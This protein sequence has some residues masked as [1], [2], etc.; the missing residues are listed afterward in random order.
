MADSASEDAFRQW[1]RA[2][3]LYIVS[4]ATCT[5]ALAWLVLIEFGIILASLSSRYADTEKG[6]EQLGYMA[7]VSALLALPLPIFFWVYNKS[8]FL[9]EQ[10]RLGD[11]AVLLIVV[12][13]P[14][15][16]LRTLLAALRWGLVAAALYVAWWAAKKGLDYYNG[17]DNE[18]TNGSK[19]YRYDPE[20]DSLFVDANDSVELAPL[21]AYDE[22]DPRQDWHWISFS[23]RV[24]CSGG[25]SYKV[26]SFI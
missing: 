20:D 18:E 25:T 10:D 19:T 2:T 11:S 17:G 23:A 16:V 21:I 6:W 13:S 12:V 7:I 1:T 14:S 3:L 15:T 4:T 26:S 22:P 5:A 9:Y 24:A 8:N